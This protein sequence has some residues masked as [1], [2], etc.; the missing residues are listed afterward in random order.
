MVGAQW[1]LEALKS[2]GS[3]TTCET[4]K[5]KE[6]VRASMGVELKKQGDQQ[7]MKKGKAVDGPQSTYAQDCDASL[8]P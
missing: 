4:K 5:R 7:L 8:S 6:S 1:N 3:A 2:E